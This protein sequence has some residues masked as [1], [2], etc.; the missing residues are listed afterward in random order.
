M[1]LVT[2]GARYPRACVGRVEWRSWILSAFLAARALGPRGRDFSRGRLPCASRA[3]GRLTGGHALTLRLAPCP[4][5]ALE[6]VLIE[7]LTR[8]GK[9]GRFFFFHVVP[10]VLGKD[11]E[12]CLE[13]LVAAATRTQQRNQ[14]PH[15]LV[16]GISLEHVDAFVG[17]LGAAA[18][19]S[20]EKALLDRDMLAEG[21]FN[22]LC[23]G[24][25]LRIAGF[26]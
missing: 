8:K 18:Q 3:C 25:R 11:L 1:D 7:Q 21:D 19:R 5:H 6:F 23:Q 22:S 15:H 16:L 10:D 14:V 26:K 13:A 2:P 9:H 12:F 20:V 24:G 4:T 17:V